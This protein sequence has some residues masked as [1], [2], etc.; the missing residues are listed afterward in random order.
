MVIF[1]IVIV[2]VCCPRLHLQSAP[3]HLLLVVLLFVLFV[4]LVLFVLFVLH[5]LCVLLLCLSMC[6]QG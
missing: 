1:R 5:L 3:V 2:I 6:C 4:L